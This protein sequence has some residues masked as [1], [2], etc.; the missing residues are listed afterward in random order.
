IVKK[1]LV[2]ATALLAVG[3]ATNVKAEEEDNAVSTSVENSHSKVFEVDGE[4]SNEIVV[5]EFKTGDT[6]IN[7][8]LPNMPYG[9]IYTELSSENKEEP[10][11]N[12]LM[13]KEKKIEIPCSNLEISNSRINH[14]ISCEP[15][16]INLGKNRADQW[17]NYSV[18]FKEGLS[19]KDRIVFRVYDDGHGY[20]TTKVFHIPITQKLLE[21]PI[22]GTISQSVENMNEGNR[23]Y[24]G[25]EESKILLAHDSQ[26]WTQRTKKYINEA[27][28]GFKYYANPINWFTSWWS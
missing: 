10:T 21:V 26:S 22:D 5:G 15:R 7:L 23:F 27:W 4:D 20:I 16:V 11:K 3:L 25:E 28:E 14:A 13:E 12:A 19:E 2:L 6:K 24:E 1:K 9:Y 17:G 8:N 18:E